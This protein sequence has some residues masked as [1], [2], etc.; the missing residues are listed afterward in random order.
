MTQKELFEIAL[1]YK[2]KGYNTEQLRYGD[3]LYD[4]TAEEI[5]DCLEI[6]WEIEREGTNWAYEQLK[7]L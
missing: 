2:E 1:K 3:D 5:S 4:A 7:K 6:F